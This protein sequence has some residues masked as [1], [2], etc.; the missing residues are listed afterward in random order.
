MHS[1]NR[2]NISKLLDAKS[3]I[4]RLL[5]CSL[6]PLFVVFEVVVVPLL[7]LELPDV[8]MTLLPVTHTNE[9]TAWTRYMY[10]VKM[11]NSSPI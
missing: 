2:S 8:T 6:E 10:N 1:S 5:T 4:D 3:Q 11:H 7:L 9:D